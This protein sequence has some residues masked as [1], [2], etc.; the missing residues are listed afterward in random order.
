MKPIVVSFALILMIFTQLPAQDSANQASSSD[1]N[2]KL[3]L[4]DQK[5]SF[6]IGDPIRLVLEFTSDHAG[7]NV[8][9]ISDRD[10]FA[11][12]ISI[13]PDTGLSRWH[14]E[15]AGGRVYARDYISLAKLSSTPVAVTL[16]LNDTL[17]FDK[18]GHYTV[19]LTTRR[20]SN[21]NGNIRLATNDVEFDIQPMT[22]EE[23]RAE[24]K[25]IIS[26]AEAS[27]DIRAN[28]VLAAQLS[29][30][31]GEAATREKVQ[32]FLH[33][34]EHGGKLNSSVP[35][36][37]YIARD[38]DLVQQLLERAV[39]DPAQS[40][41]PPVIG[42]LTTLRLMKERSGQPVERKVV[43]PI[44]LAPDQ[45]TLEIQHGYLS[46]LALNLNKRTG[47][48]LRTT[49][50]TILMLVPAN[51]P[52]RSSLIAESRRVL[53]S[54]F[55]QLNPIDQEYL[56]ERY[57]GDLNS[58]VG[59]GVL[60]QMLGYDK[61][62]SLNVHNTALQ[63]IIELSSDEARP[64]VVKEICDP[65][66][67]VAA[68][69]IGQLDD[70]ELP[71]VDRCL[72]AQLKQYVKSKENSDRFGFEYKASLAVRF[73]TDNVYRELADIYRDNRSAL[74]LAARAS[75]LAYLAKHNEAE[76][77]PLIEQELSEITPGEDFN[78][79][80]Q[81]AQQYYSVSLGEVIKKRLES[82]IPEYASNAAYLLG[83]YGPVAD[84]KVLVARLERW[85][86]DWKER[87]AETEANHQGMIE[88]ELVWA[89]VH[90][91]SWK[92]SAEQAKKFQLSCLSQMCKQSNQAP[93]Q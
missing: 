67:L 9:T 11:D 22:A 2:V 83:K 64:F 17:R 80:P 55:D 7:Y 31:T 66:S 54:Q 18:P 26:L 42:L 21:K 84:E 51:D 69:I 73:A 19:K 56:L 25:R 63:R 20:V 1:V 24:L 76:A 87:V 86:N 49:A 45:R 53:G 10:D 61:V 89:L 44:T 82:D 15:M 59:L 29:Y 13:A 32:I 93:V 52:Q 27:S 91:E 35:A 70:K 6:R 81:L 47:D 85:R 43:G 40:V 16:T 30:L 88:R 75:L 65:R 58:Y 57:W 41:T 12:T 36:G 5:A 78:F 48:S 68:K 37:L 46:E 62:A 14:E 4:A 74:S 28:Y 3:L 92:L 72:A 71:E 77:V 50:Q 39:Q 23:E 8:D 60:K 79:L 90:N 34:G 38:R 33:P